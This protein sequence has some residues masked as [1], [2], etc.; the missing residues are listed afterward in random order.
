MV[1]GGCG[2]VLVFVIEAVFVVDGTSAEARVFLDTTISSADSGY[3]DLRT[4]YYHLLPRTA[5]HPVC[6]LHSSSYQRLT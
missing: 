2:R 6:R 3:G 5:T 1:S 4:L